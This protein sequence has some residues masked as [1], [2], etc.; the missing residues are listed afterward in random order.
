MYVHKYICTRI[1]ASGQFQESNKLPHMHAF[2]HIILNIIGNVECRN[3]L[4][5]M[6]SKGLHCTQNKQQQRQR[7][8]QHEQSEKFDLITLTWVQI[9][10]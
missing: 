10:T 3:I 8:Q 1:S 5:E 6:L 7:Q 9:S 4:G 2:M